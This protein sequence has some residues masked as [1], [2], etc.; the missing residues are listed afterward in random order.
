MIDIFSRNE[1]E[2]GGQRPSDTQEINYPDSEDDEFLRIKMSA[3]NQSVIPWLDAQ[4]VT[5]G[6]NVP[7]YGVGLYHRGSSN[8]GGFLAYRLISIDYTR[9]M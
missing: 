9:F 6:G 4:S 1:L 5:S 7:L 3:N 8:S 2:I